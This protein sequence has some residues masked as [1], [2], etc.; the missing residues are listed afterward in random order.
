MFG[1]QRP[2]PHPAQHFCRETIKSYLQLVTGGGGISLRFTSPALDF[3][4]GLASRGCLPPP[5]VG[6]SFASAERAS[7]QVQ[8]LENQSAS[9]LPA[10]S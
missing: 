5:S 4:K 1:I 7:P 6:L 3:P 8:I 9:A 2:I 10:P